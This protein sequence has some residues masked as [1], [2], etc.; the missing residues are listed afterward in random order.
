MFL[1]S[2]ELTNDAEDAQNVWSKYHQHVD[3]G[4]QNESNADVT[5]P[6]EGL[7]GE[8]HVLDRSTYL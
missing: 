8:R 7:F 5:Q 1:C 2:A 3:D 6:A 4:E